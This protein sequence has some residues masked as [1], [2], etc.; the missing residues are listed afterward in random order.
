VKLLK[1]LLILGLTIFI[2][3]CASYKHD[4]MDA[5]KADGNTEEQC[6]HA[7]QY[8]WRIYYSQENPGHDG[9]TV[10][11]SK[12]TTEEVS[13]ELDKFL[14]ALKNALD[15]TNEE[16]ATFI[17]TYNLRKPMERKERIL[18]QVRAGIQ[19]AVIEVKFR[20]AMGELSNS[21]ME[22]AR[23]YS[24]KKIFLPGS[25][26]RFKFT[27][28][29]IEEAK[30]RGV[31]KSFEH[32]VFDLHREL[33]KKGKDPA[34]PEDFPREF[35]WKPKTMALDLTNYKIWDVQK[36]DN[37]LGNYIEGYRVIDGKKESKPALKIFF[38]NGLAAAIIVVD[39][40][41]EGKDP[42]FGLPDYVEKVAGIVSVKNVVAGLMN[43]EPTLAKLFEEK[44]EEKRVPPQLKKIY[45]EVRPLGEP[46]DPWDKAQ[47]PEGWLVPFKYWNE[48]KRNNYNVRVKFKK[49]HDHNPEETTPD[50]REIEWIAKEYTSGSDRHTPAVGEVSE[51]Y[52]AKGDFAQK[53]KAEVLF[54]EDTKRIRFELENGESKVVTVT[55]A[56]NLVI[57]DK[58][59]AIRYKEG[60]RYWWLEKSHGSNVFDK[61]KEVTKSK[62]TTGRYDLSD[63]EE[64]K[65]QMPGD[66]RNRPIEKPKG[67]SP[68]S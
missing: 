52:R 63:D 2:S 9:Y 29:Q 11:Y 39:S 17:E 20:E 19:T 61:R 66:M 38:P 60:E 57:E 12:L 3:S 47:G 54:N 26:D 24:S 30:K 36:P 59:F 42:G 32:I 65:G 16:W 49:A 6:R 34:H 35:R 62:E 7:Y 44:E 25:A 33:D 50:F 4:F 23:G 53:V 5:C 67:V 37:N 1:T 48:P 15:Y 22:H 14:S 68:K 21:D 28:D 31:L 43:D 64:E 10:I 13:N 46:I 55:P 27:S 56:S 8:A 40:K 18:N 51:F 58:P 41:R 45:V